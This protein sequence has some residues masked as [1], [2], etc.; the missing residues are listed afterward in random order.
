MLTRENSRANL[1]AKRVTLGLKLSPRD[2]PDGHLQSSNWKLPT[3]NLESQYTIKLEIG[4]GCADDAHGLIS[5][6]LG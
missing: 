3:A 2:R 6:N 1:H 4:A 5:R